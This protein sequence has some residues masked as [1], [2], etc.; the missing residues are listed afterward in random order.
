MTQWHRPHLAV[1][2]VLVVFHCKIKMKIPLVI[3]VLSPAKMNLMSVLKDIA[4][5]PYRTP[6]RWSSSLFVSD[7]VNLKVVYIIKVDD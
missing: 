6:K 2:E 5:L 7:N 3:S 4:V 1:M